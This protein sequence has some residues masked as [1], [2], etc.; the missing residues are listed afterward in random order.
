MSSSEDDHKTTR[1]SAR[2]KRRGRACDLCR[3]KKVRCDGR[4]GERCSNCSASQQECTYVREAKKRYPDAERIK[5]L[6]TELTNYKKLLNKLHPGVDFSRELSGILSDNSLW[7]LDAEQKA[8]SSA[9]VPLRLPSPPSAPN[10]R[11]SQDTDPG[12]FESSDEELT[13]Q[14]ELKRSMA[15]LSL[16]NEYPRYLGKSSRLRFFKKAYDMK[17]MYTG[18]EN[19]TTL[20]NERLRQS[21][22]RVKYIRSQP[23]IAPALEPTPLPPYDFP[24]DDLMGQLIDLYFLELNCHLP[25]L[26]RPTF[27]TCVESAL[28]YEDEGFASLLLLVCAI[29]ARFSFDKRVLSEGTQNWHSAGWKWFIQVVQHRKGI[30][31]R[32]PRLYDIQIP[33]LIYCY[34][35]GSCVTQAAWAQIGYGLRLAQDM[36]AHRKRSYGNSPTIEGELMKRAFWILVALDR[37]LCLSLGRQCS[38]EDEDMDLDYPLEVDDE[39]WVS[40]DSDKAFKQPE[41]KPSMVSYFNSS[42]RLKQIQAFALRTIYSTKKAK[43][44]SGRTGPEWEQQIITDL[45]SALNQWMDSVPDHLRWDPH[46]EDLAFLKQSSFLYSS[47]YG[48]QINIHRQ[49]IPLPHK[50]S[51]LAFPSL[52]I[53][54]NAARSTIH[55]L[56][57]QFR[58]SGLSPFLNMAGLFSSGIVLLMNIWGSK[59][60][61]VAINPAKELG[62]VHRTMEILKSLEG[63][64]YSAG[65]YREVLHE[66]ANVGDVPLPQGISRPPKRSHEESTMN[67]AGPSVST[68]SSASTPSDRPTPDSHREIAGSRRVSLQQSPVLPDGSPPSSDGLFSPTLDFALPMHSD[69]LGRI[70]IFSGQMQNQMQGQMQP[71]DP[72]PVMPERGWA[73]FD[74]APSSFRSVDPDAGLTTMAAPADTTQ[75]VGAF[76]GQYAAE[77]LSAAFAS[78]PQQQMGPAYQMQVGSNRNGI[79]DNTLAMW[80]T[81]PGNF[82]WDEWGMFISSMNGQEQGAQ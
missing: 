34:L 66:L 81:A 21:V 14:L 79:A 39:Y 46:K 24:P 17:N 51:K 31:L 64:W 71:Q 13:F 72:L 16:T 11:P 10:P 40:S 1:D 4:P 7:L 2:A 61:S 18:G 29:G 22:C 20:L 36:G 26:H 12:E 28:H 70:P 80:S 75:F 52:A 63:R 74:M 27:E 54:T 42:L 47:Y 9:Q 41:G 62:E 15:A 73:G 5:Q 69:E 60:S 44:L 59:Q 78:V 48:T 53:C 49:F 65:R 37:S 32:L 77:A 23:W 45:D 3:H 25:L 35:H 50:P 43:V 55:V 6:E 82:D 33:C 38:L 8:A 57:T 56:D 30:M 67:G 19:G 76:S 58:R 68:P